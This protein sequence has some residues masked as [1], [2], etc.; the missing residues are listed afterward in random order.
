MP[1]DPD[2]DQEEFLDGCLPALDQRRRP[3]LRRA[4]RRWVTLTLAV[5]AAL[6]TLAGM[7]CFVVALA[8]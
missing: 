4:P 2:Y 5:L 7:V 6:A 1:N 3:E 8:L